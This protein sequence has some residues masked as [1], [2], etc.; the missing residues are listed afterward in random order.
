MWFFISTRVVADRR[1]PFPG[2]VTVTGDIMLI[3]DLSFPLS[4]FCKDMAYSDVRQVYTGLWLSPILAEPL[5]PLRPLVFHRPLVTPCMCGSWLCH[6]HHLAFQA[7]GYLEERRLCDDRKKL[8]Y[9]C[10]NP[11]GLHILVK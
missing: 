3:N 4:R 8:E 10:G 11:R 5:I 7:G 2:L 6:F 9:R 1:T